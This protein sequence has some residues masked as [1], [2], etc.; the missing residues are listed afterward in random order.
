MQD[1]TRSSCGER[2]S[3]LIA[4]LRKGGCTVAE[5]TESRTG[6]I[7]GESTEHEDRRTDAAIREEQ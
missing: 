1:Q 3:C 4:C 7:D 2:L 6:D 5:E